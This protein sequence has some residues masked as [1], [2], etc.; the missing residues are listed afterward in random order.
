M[1][2]QKTNPDNQKANLN[3][4]KEQGAGEQGEKTKMDSNQN[5]KH[6]TRN[7]GQPGG[8]DRNAQDMASEHRTDVR[9]AD[10]GRLPNDSGNVHDNL[11]ESEKEIENEE[12]GQ[13]EK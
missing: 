2:N 8:S 12:G 6:S 3:E 4:Q 9:N 11:R 7:Q 1:K 10:R 13:N 5:K